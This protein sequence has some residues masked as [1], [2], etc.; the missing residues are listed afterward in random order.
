MVKR[1]GGGKFSLIVL[2]NVPITNSSFHALTGQED[3]T[4]HGS[5]RD[6]KVISD[7]LVFVTPVKHQ[8][9]YAVE[10]TDAIEHQFE[11]LHTHVVFSL[12]GDSIAT[13]QRKGKILY[14][15][16]DV[17]TALHLPVP[18]DVSVSHNRG[19][20]AFEIGTHSK[21]LLVAV[22]PQAC[23]LHEVLGILT[24]AGQTECKGEKEAF[25]LIEL[26]GKFFVR[27]V[28]SGVYKNSVGVIIA[29]NN[30]QIPC[31]KHNAMIYNQ[32]KATQTHALQS[33][34]NK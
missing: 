31:Q 18:V 21:L 17:L 32:L 8:E 28:C 19:N 23:F 7:L 16:V 29:P 20:P 22:G 33:N 24:V 10:L 27:H 2:V 30:N 12:I 13:F 15:L 1:L 34:K 6:G 11:F 26:L 4:L 5:D 9:G 25:E 14:G 3:A